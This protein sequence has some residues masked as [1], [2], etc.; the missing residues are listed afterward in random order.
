[1]KSKPSPFAL[2][3]GQAIIHRELRR[4]KELADEL[5]LPPIKLTTILSQ[6]L[7]E[8]WEQKQIRQIMVRFNRWQRR[9]YQAKLE[10]QFHTANEFVEPPPE[11]WGLGPVHGGGGGHS[12]R[13]AA[14]P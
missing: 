4:L 9:V 2:L 1:M 6:G 8:T 3:L 13:Y 11:V 5:R 10:Q 12:R 14:G 7:P